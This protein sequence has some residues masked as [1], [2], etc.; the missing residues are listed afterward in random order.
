VQ[1]LSESVILTES[2][3]SFLSTY[4]YFG[5]EFLLSVTYIGIM[6]TKHCVNSLTASFCPAHLLFFL[7]VSIMFIVIF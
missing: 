1:H 2:D 3:L 5:D 7:V 6:T 4:G